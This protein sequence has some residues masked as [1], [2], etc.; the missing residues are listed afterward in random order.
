MSDPD[1]TPRD[2]DGPHDIP[3]ARNFDPDTSHEAGHSIERREGT[4]TSLRPRTSKHLAL[5]AIAV[6]PRTANE[7]V[8]ATGKPGIWKRVSDLKN[9][10]LIEPVSKRRDPV[11]KEANTV[12]TL[13]G[14]GL[15]V[16]RLLDRGESVR[17]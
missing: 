4:T 9:A 7:V 6:M 1:E 2:E 16:L 14:Q 11:T 10:E 8:R 17:L 13:T 3:H 5:A 15:D 12:W